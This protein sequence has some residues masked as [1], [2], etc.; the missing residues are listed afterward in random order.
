MDRSRNL[1]ERARSLEMTTF[2]EFWTLVAECSSILQ[3]IAPKKRRN[4]LGQVVMEL[5][6]E[7]NGLCGLCEK[8]MEPDAYEVDHKIPFAYGGGHERTNLQLAHPE[9][10]RWKGASVDPHHLLDTL[11]YLEDRYMNR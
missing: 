3:K 4:W 2:R 6:Q 9:C 5:Y 10:N 7:Q 11:E 8:P 1:R